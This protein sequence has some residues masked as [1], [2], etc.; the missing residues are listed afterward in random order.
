MTQNGQ[1]QASSD[2][3]KVLQTTEEEKTSLET[4]IRMLQSKVEN[5]RQDCDSVLTKN[6]Q[7]HVEVFNSHKQTTKMESSLN[8]AIENEERLEKE[9]DETKMILDTVEKDFQLMVGRNKKMD[10]E[11]RNAITKL[12]KEESAVENL[13]RETERTSNILKDMEAKNESLTTEVKLLNHRINN[14]TLI[15]K[16]Q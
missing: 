12:E 8:R 3:D 9:L 2:V 13:T 6:A 14:L 7:L 16:H 1:D 4:Q 10:E 5:L 11:L 15:T